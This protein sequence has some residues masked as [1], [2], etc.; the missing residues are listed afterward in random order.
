MLVQKIQGQEVLSCSKQLWHTCDRLK[1]VLLSNWV[2]LAIKALE[3]RRASME[4]GSGAVR[5]SQ[6]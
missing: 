4:T 5:G 3:Q 6:N 1:E 2:S